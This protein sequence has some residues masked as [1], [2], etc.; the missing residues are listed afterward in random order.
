V[1]LTVACAAAQAA[2]GPL[3]ERLRTEFLDNPLGIDSVSPQVS[4]QFVESGRGARQSA[5]RIQAAD[6]LAALTAGKANLWD[7]GK[8]LSRETANLRLPGVAMKSG[9]TCFWRV[10]VWNAADVA[11]PFSPPARFEM[12][13]LHAGDWR[14]AWLT[15]EVTI[16]ANTDAAVWVPKAGAAMDRVTEGGRPVWQQ[17]KFV[18]GVAGITAAVDAGEWVRFE[19]GAGSYKF[20]SFGAVWAG[21]LLKAAGRR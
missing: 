21:S 4:W 10:R 13:L 1:V 15:L 18:P 2:P 5:Y 11:G 20:V 6:T 9:G 19:V 14:G 8:V 17:G 12:G 16:P 3:A 7:S